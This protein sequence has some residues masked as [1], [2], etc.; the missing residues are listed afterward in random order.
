MLSEPQQITW[1][2]KVMDAKNVSSNMER[3]AVKRGFKVSD[4][5]SRSGDC[6]FYALSEQ[7]ERVKKIRIPHDEVRKRLILFLRE[8]PTLVSYNST[9]LFGQSIKMR[10]WTI[11]AAVVDPATAAAGAVTVIVVVTA[12]AKAAAAAA[13]ADEM[14]QK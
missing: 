10:F 2:T 8:N 6:M 14:V 9:I 5:Y 3:I 13:V 1:D 11:I 4:K 12:V 7:L